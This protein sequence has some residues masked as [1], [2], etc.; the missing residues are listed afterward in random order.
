MRLIS[1][2][3]LAVSAL[4]AVAQIIPPVPYTG[5]AKGVVF[6]D[7]NRN[8]VRDPGER[9]IGGVRVSN[10]REVV[11]TDRNGNWQL[12]HT[13]DT[14]F[15]VVKPR[16]WMTPVDEHKVP[17]FYYNHKPQGSPK[18]KH[19]GVA[20]TG[21]LP[22][23]IDFPLTKV[24]ESDKFTALFFGDT[25]PRDLREVD[26]LAR[27]IIEPL[28]GNP[29]GGAFGVT[30]GDV[31]FDDLSVTE[32]LVRTIGM[33]GIPWYYVLGNHDINYDATDDRFSDEH[34]ER[35][36]GPSYYSF[37][38]GP[39]HFVVLDNVVWTSAANA[40]DQKQGYK[41]GLGAAQLEWLKQD[42]AHVPSN[43]LVVLCMHIP[44][45]EIQDRAQ[46]F[47]II[48]QR[49]YCL[50]VS[51]HT[52]MQEHRF[53]ST[54]D[55]W[56]KPEPHHHVINVTTCGSWWTGAPGPLGV[57][58]TT[59]R[60]GAPHGYSLFKF[61]GNQYSIEFRAAR[62]PASYQMNIYA[63]ESLKVSE[64]RGA[65]VYVNVFGGS[66]KSKVEMSL[67]DGKWRSMLRALEADPEYKKAALREAKLEKPYRPLSGP[68]I[69]THL[70]K[71]PLSGYDKPG[72]YPIHVRTTDMFGQVFVSTRSI[73]IE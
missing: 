39:T 68:E 17:R 44:M 30:L 63:P 15:F 42:L 29:D 70:W 10:M 49:P 52:H 32:P 18:L 65:M 33:I 3:I 1:S 2:V 8:G 71:L 69:S 47:E 7:T 55:G 54:K 25:Q 45:T 66:E 43:Q 72:V 22:V 31:V 59:M 20:P 67:G 21:P 27:D 73:R 60:D 12:G 9:G 28:I 23:S 61:D 64:A 5:T 57:P 40:P 36:F 62:R 14:M 37:D 11:K 38:Y 24:K 16:G 19:S 26:Y 35:V 6:D 46:L 4:P 13:D 41:A 48:E 51:A 53:I 34:W 56:K 50:S 58:H